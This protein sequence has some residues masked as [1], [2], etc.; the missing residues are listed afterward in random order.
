MTIAFIPARGGSKGLPR[1]NIKFFMGEPLIS[2]AIRIAKETKIFNQIIVNTDDDEIAKIAK[3]GGANILRRPRVL[4]NDTAE[5][6]PLIK[7]SIE[8]L[9]ISKNSTEIITLL[10][11]TAPLRECKDII[12]TIDLVK[13]QGFDSALT[14]VET[15]YYLWKLNE[16]S[17]TPT[18][19]DPTKRAARQTEKWNQFMENKA[20]YAFRVADLMKSGCRLN[21]K[22]GGCIMDADRSIDIDSQEDF[23]IA[24]A[25]ANNKYI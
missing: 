17:F 16:N 21:G 13:N 6:D 2:R 15:N 11:C 5:V 20:V 24:E 7:W 19:Y 14:L 23:N 10:Y 18:N 8:E 25:I 12:N 9:G 3:E 22:V 4:G 1:K